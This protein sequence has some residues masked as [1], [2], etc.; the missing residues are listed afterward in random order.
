MLSVDLGGGGFW[1]HSEFMV[2][3]LQ[4]YDMYRK[5]ILGVARKKALASER[6]ALV[7]PTLVST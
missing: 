5:S 6:I 7:S 2:L 4:F 3:A 1:D